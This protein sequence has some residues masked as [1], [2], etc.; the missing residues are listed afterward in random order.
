VSEVTPT[1]IEN[2]NILRIVA[3][4]QEKKGMDILLLDLREVTDLLDYFLLCT[5]SSP[6]HV[7]ALAE[8]VERE[9]K[10]ENE[11]PLHVEGLKEGR[12]VLLDYVDV[13][14]HIFRRETREFYALERLW[15]D[16]PRTA[17]E[18]SAAPDPAPETRPGFQ[19]ARS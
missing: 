17:F 16:A 6:Q 12:W 2:P 9:L 11:R 4:L 19:F 8:E 13:A 7:K 1:P 5:G 3:A 18:S 14:V 15:G 10:R